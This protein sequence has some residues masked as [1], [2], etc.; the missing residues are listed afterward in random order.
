MY[1]LP[2]ASPRRFR[3]G[4]FEADTANGRLLR[5]GVR[6]PLQEVPFRFLVALLEC[7]GQIVG[8][9]QLRAQ[10]WP[11]G[12][13][14]DFDASLDTA[15]RK[16]RRAL[17]DSAREPAYFETVPGRGYRFLKEVHG[18]PGTPWPAPGPAPGSWARRWAPILATALLLALLPLGHDVRPLAMAPRPA[19]PP[20]RPPRVLALPAKVLGPPDQGYLA[21]ALPAMLSTLLATSRDLDTRLPPTSLELEP[22]R[23]D[24][25]QVAR[26]YRA[27]YLIHSTLTLQDGRM[28]L[29]LQLADAATR[30]ITWARQLEGRREDCP[31]LA[32][33]A[34]AALKDALKSGGAPLADGALLGTKAE[35]ALEEGNHFASRYWHRGQAPDFA[36]A[37]AAFRR[38]EGL[39]PDRADGT[40]GLAMLLNDRFWRTHAPGDLRS[41]QLA[42]DRALA[43]D[44]GCARAWMVRSKMVANSPVNTPEKAVAYAVKAACLAPGDPRMQHGLG[45]EVDGFNGILVAA[46]KQCMELDP[47]DLMGY[48]WTALGLIWT[49][50]SQEAL[51]V[52]DQALALDPGHT[53]NRSLR[54]MALFHLGRMAEARG[55][56]TAA[57]GAEARGEP[58]ALMLAIAEGDLPRARRIAANRKAAW[59]RAKAVS[60]MD[61]ANRAAF[62]AP[63]FARLGLREEA[64]GVLEQSVEANHPPPYDW[65]SADPDLRRLAGEPRFTR[66]LAASRAYASVCAAS[67][68]EAR[69]RRGLPPYL[70]PPLAA[71][72]TLLGR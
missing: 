24:P 60:S 41:A 37:L 30:Q 36:R 58:E 1:P 57:P 45:T 34:A 48:S 71:L 3:F 50:R 26:L 20:S 53:F 54:F 33:T 11:G 4:A 62:Y 63:L 25:A 69:R 9:D 51:R 67:L 38:L 64:L 39:A 27:D 12:L 7:P 14:I 21:D 2:I 52:L 66:V 46:G 61:R 8:R 15:A 42:V 44:R 10:I 18:G 16:L 59:T 43:R 17:G 23:G 72:Q 55:A 5:A 31:D 40:G 28:V 19:P 65:L 49:G 29:D 56:W 6:V 70:D 32:R 22:V 68:E 47:L 35:L 13:H